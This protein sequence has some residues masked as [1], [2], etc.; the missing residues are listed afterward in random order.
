MVALVLTI[1][2]MLILVTITVRTGISSIEHSR[3]ANFVSRMQLIQ[4]KVD[5]LAENGGYE[6][7][8]DDLDVEKTT[9]LKTALYNENIQMSRLPS[10]FQEVEYIEGTGT[11]YIDT[12][13]F[14]KSNTRVI[15]TFSYTGSNGGQYSNGMLFRKF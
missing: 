6:D 13:Y 7:L 3:M 4:K 11:Q 9:Q 10:E 5:F 12:N 1:V 8:G 14:A 2:V 15:M